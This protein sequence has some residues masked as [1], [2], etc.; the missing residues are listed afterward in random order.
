MSNV[1]QA[2]ILVCVG[3]AAAGKRIA[4]APGM[5]RLGV[6]VSSSPRSVGVFVYLRHTFQLADGPF[7]CLAPQGWSDSD[8]LAELLTKYSVTA[9]R[10][11]AG[12]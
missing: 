5:D 6:P 2:K 10:K 3:G 11:R 4:V 9:S 8:V 12:A 7:Q 1:E